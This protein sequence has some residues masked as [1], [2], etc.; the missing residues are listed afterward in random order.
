MM[1]TAEMARWLGKTLHQ[2]GPKPGMGCAGHGRPSR[3]IAEYTPQVRARWWKRIVNLMGH[4]GEPLP[5]ILRIA[6]VEQTVYTVA[7]CRTFGAEWQ[8]ICPSC[9]QRCRTVYLTEWRGVACRVCSELLYL[10]QRFRRTSGWW[11]WEPAFAGWKRYDGVEEVPEFMQEVI[12]YLKRAARA[13][14]RKRMETL[15]GKAEG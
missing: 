4:T 8:F 5:L 7:I 3:G 11:F 9:G 10:S 13:Q 12:P 2:R 15:L 6:G 14:L 1:D